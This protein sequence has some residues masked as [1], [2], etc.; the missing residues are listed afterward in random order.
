MEFYEISGID[1]TLTFSCL[2]KATQYYKNLSFCILFY[3]TKVCFL[4]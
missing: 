2:Q 1:E 4:F 3:V